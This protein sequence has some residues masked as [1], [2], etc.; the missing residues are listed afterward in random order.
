M[1]RPLSADGQDL[2]RFFNRRRRHFTFVL[3]KVSDRFFFKSK[4]RKEGVKIERVGINTTKPKTNCSSVFTA[5]RV[6]IV[7]VT[8]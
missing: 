1:V 6:F 4:E 3:Q 2:D 8:L 7:M 5:N